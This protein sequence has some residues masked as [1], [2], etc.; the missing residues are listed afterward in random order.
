ML[1]YT[2]ASFSN[3]YCAPTAAKT[4]RNICLAKF[5]NNKLTT[6]IKIRERIQFISEAFHQYED[7]TATRPRMMNAPTNGGFRICEIHGTIVRTGTQIPTHS[8]RKT[9]IYIYRF[10]IC[11]YTRHA[12]HSIDHN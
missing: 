9:D 3:I 7:K 2:L 4:P 8:I 5:Q 10:C 12:R 6:L 1:C 11:I